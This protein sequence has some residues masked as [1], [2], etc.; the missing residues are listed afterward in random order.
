MISFLP[1]D[2]QLALE[3]C[4][5]VLAEKAAVVTFVEP[6]PAHPAGGSGLATAPASI[7]VEAERRHAGGLRLMLF[8]VHLFLPVGH[9]HTRELLIDIDQPEI[10]GDY[11]TRAGA[12]AHD[13]V[14]ELAKSLERRCQEN[15][16]RLQP[17][18]LAELL[19]DLEQVL[20]DDLQEELRSHPAGKQKLDG[21]ELSRFV[22]QWAEQMNYL[23]PGLLVSLRESLQ[24][25][26]QARRLSALHR[27]EVEGAGAWLNWPVG[28][29][30]VWLESAAGFAVACYGLINHLAAIA[31]LYLTGL[32]KKDN[33]RDKITEG[34]WRGVVL[35]GCYVVQVFLV[36]HFWGRRAA[37]YYAPTL[38]LS[39]L[40]LW[41]YAWLLR[42][43]TRIAFLAF[44]LS[45]ETART[46]RLRIH[47]LYEINRVLDQYAALLDLPH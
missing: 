11:L 26:R 19:G 15:S 45:A 4:C 46:K 33:G 38:P 5:A 16:F 23:H 37:G 12:S 30:L 20:R 40:Y 36:A 9:S 32:L 18:D 43:Q 42:H 7:A 41:R 21:F 25:W 17:A 39:A 22:V 27:L 28:R 24:A 3:R 34:L 31:L 13:P 47:F 6:G 10:A 8:P 14:Q 29:S 35:L 2:R 44:K 1:E